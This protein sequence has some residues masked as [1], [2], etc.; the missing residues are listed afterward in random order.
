[1]AG[2]AGAEVQQKFIVADR[3]KLHRP[4]KLVAVRDEYRTWVRHR[5]PERGNCC[6]GEVVCT[7]VQSSASFRYFIL[8]SPIS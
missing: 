1:M 5:N 4:Y 6:C 7:L 2:D 3:G 8:Q